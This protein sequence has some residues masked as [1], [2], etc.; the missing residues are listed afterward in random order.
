MKEELVKEMNDFA[1]RVLKGGEN[2]H[3]QE[4]AI[5]PQILEIL[6]RLPGKKKTDRRIG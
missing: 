3:P 1:I 5:L 2:A 4:I 6:E